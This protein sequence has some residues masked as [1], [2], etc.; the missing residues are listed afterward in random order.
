MKEIQLSQ[1]KV[2]LIDDDDFERVNQFK[3]SFGVSKRDKTIYVKRRDWSKKEYIKLHRF[4]LNAPKNKQVDHIDGNGLNNQKSNLRLCSQS[5]NKRNSKIYSNNTSGYKG[6]T[7][8]RSNS[9]WIA[10]VMVNKKYVNFGSYKT[11]EEA[12]IAYNNAAIKH[13][14]NFARINVL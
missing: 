12:A 11:K 1:G 9:K 2:A 5:E 13:Y 10:R 4:I 8:S 14:G 6:V 7:F 3:W